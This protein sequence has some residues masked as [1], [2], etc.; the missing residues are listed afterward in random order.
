MR[1]NET[2]RKQRDLQEE[3]L[4]ALWNQMELQNHL[5]KKKNWDAWMDGEVEAQIE[6]EIQEYLAASSDPTVYLNRKEAKAWNRMP[7]SKRGSCRKDP[8]RYSKSGRQGSE[9]S[10]LATNG[11]RRIPWKI[12]SFCSQGLP[13]R[14]CRNQEG[15]DRKGFGNQKECQECRNHP[16]A[17]HFPRSVRCRVHPDRGELAGQEAGILGISGRESLDPR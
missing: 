4:E 5:K 9:R 8:N 17:M 12:W 2:K 13:L 14:E 10:S 3:E 7:K 1:L 16:E 11:I 6:E 15:R